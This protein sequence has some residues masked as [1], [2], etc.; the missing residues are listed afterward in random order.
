[1]VVRHGDVGPAVAVEVGDGQAVRLRPRGE[2]DRGQEGA[3]AVAPASSETS[4]LPT[5]PVMM[6]SLPSPLKSARVMGYGMSP[7][8][9]VWPVRNVPS[10]LPS[11]TVTYEGLDEPESA[12]TRSGMPSPL[13]SPTANQAAPGPAGTFRAG[14]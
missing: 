3:V 10:P 11:R 9:K 12:T 6:S 5:L 7:T 4:L 14:A 1:M 13:R 2:L 8:A